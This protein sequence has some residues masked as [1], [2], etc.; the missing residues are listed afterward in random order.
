MKYPNRLADI[1]RAAGMSQ[2]QMAEEFGMSLSA[3][4]NF[5]YG[6]RDMKGD[7]IITIAKRFNCSSDYILCVDSNNEDIT[8][9]ASGLSEDEAERIRRYIQ[10]EKSQQD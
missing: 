5:E 6:Y 8:E 1:R 10:F 2:Q 3:Y 4:R 9:L 7:F